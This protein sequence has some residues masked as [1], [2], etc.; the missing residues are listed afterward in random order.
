MRRKDPEYATRLRSDHRRPFGK[1]MP[2][3]T[4]LDILSNQPCREEHD[5]YAVNGRIAQRLGVVGAKHAGD[6]H[7]LE[8]IAWLGLV[9]K[10]PTIGRLQRIDKTIVLQ[11]IDRLGDR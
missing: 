4:R 8:S 3:T 2:Q 9:T 6:G 1:H 5:P 10:E 7:L 11:Q